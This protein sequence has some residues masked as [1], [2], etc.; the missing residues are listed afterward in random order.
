[1]CLDGDDIVVVVEFARFSGKAEIGDR[2][3]FV[4]FD[5]ETRGP[6]VF[7]LVLDFELKGL[8]GE[9]GELGFGRDLGIADTADLDC[10]SLQLC[11]M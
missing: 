2:R 6:F 10:I 1:V 9:I 3:D 4:V 11:G 8:V 7:G 5:L